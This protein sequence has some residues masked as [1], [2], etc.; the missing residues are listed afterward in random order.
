MLEDRV[1]LY[2]TS[3]NLTLY[4]LSPENVSI[5]Y[6]IVKLNGDFFLL[7][8]VSLNRKLTPNI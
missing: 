5:N 4:I 3:L 7:S 2:I 1:S 6:L 8:T